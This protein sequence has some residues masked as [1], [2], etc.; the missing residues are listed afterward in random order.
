MPKTANIGETI[1]FACQP[2]NASPKPSVSWFKDGREVS[3]SARVQVLDSGNLR[4]EQVTWADA[5]VYWCVASSSAFQR[6]SEKAPLTVR[7]RPYFVVA[8]ASQFVP[9]NGVLELACRVAGEPQPLIMWKRD[10]PVP[11]I[12]SNRATLLSDGS[13]RIVNVQPED[14]GNYICQASSEGGVVEAVARIDIISSPGFTS[15]PPGYVVTLEGTTIHL[16]CAASGS[17][18]PE[19]RWIRKETS[20]YYVGGITTSSDRI[21]TGET[22]S[23]II[24]SARISD[25]GT[26]ECRASSPVGLTRT[27][28][29][30]HVRPNPSLFPGRVGAVSPPIIRLSS[31]EPPDMIK[32]LCSV[33]EDSGFVKYMSID[34]AD[35]TENSTQSFPFASYDL[36]WYKGDQDLSLNMHPNNRYS[37]EPDGS[38]VIHHL[39]ESDA[40]NY[41]CSVTSLVSKR[42]A[43]WDIRLMFD[44][45]PQHFVPTVYFHLLPAAPFDLQVSAV[46]DSWISLKWH[47]DGSL[48]DRFQVFFL[49]QTPSANYV[50]PSKSVLQMTSASEENRKYQFDYWELAKESTSERRFNLLGLLPD[51][52]YWIEVR[53]FNAFGWS[54]GSIFPRPVYTQVSSFVVFPNA[55]PHSDSPEV[56]NA[57]IDKPGGGR[58]AQDFQ[59]MVSRMH[60]IAFP[61]VSARSL[62]SSEVLVSW[63]TKGS[64]GALK[65][66]DGFLISAKPVFMSR[67]LAAASSNIKANRGVSAQHWIFGGVNSY[68]G[69]L[70]NDRTYCSFSN[71]F[72]LEKIHQD[73]LLG[74]IGHL[75]TSVSSG[76][77]TS[78]RAKPIPD[79]TVLVPRSVSREDPTTGTVIGD[80]H[81]FS[82]YEISVKAFKNDLTYGK[83][84]SRETQAE[85]VMSLDSTPSQAPQLRSANWLSGHMDIKAD[86]RDSQLSIDMAF[87]GA[88]RKFST[89]SHGSLS[90]RS[91]FGGS[92]PISSHGIRLSWAPLDIHVSHGALL[93]YSIHIVANESEFSHSKKVPPDVHMHDVHGL[94]PHVEYTIFLAGIT[95]RG[96]GVRGPGYRMPVLAS[97]VSSPTRLSAAPPF[98][99]WAYGVVCGIVV[100]WITVGLL[101]YL[102]ACRREPRC[103]LHNS[104]AEAKT[105]TSVSA[106]AARTDSIFLISAPPPPST[107]TTN[108]FPPSSASSGTKS[109]QLTD[110]ESSAKAS[111]QA[112]ANLF[113]RRPSFALKNLPSDTR[114]NIELVRLLSQ[115]NSFCDTGGPRINAATTTITAVSS[116]T[117]V[118]L[119]NS[120][121]YSQEEN[122]TKSTSSGSSMTAHGQNT[123]YNGQ[124]V[125]LPPPPNMPF[126]TPMTNKYAEF[127]TADAASSTQVPL[128]VGDPAYSMVSSG[129]SLSGGVSSSFSSPMAHLQSSA[130]GSVFQTPP[131]QKQQQQQPPPSM[132]NAVFLL[133]PNT[134]NPHVVHQFASAYDPSSQWAPAFTPSMTSATDEVPPYASSCLMLPDCARNQ[135]D[136]KPD[137]APS[138]TAPPTTNPVNYLD[139]VS[140]SQSHWS[141]HPTPGITQQRQLQ[142]QL[143]LPPVL[144]VNSQSANTPNVV[145]VSTAIP[146]PP[147]YP[148]PPLPMGG[149]GGVATASAPFTGEQFR[150]LSDDGSLPSSGSALPPPCPSMFRLFS[151]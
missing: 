92:Y 56:S 74:G 114:G 108:P 97:L 62:S 64:S 124:R 89:D 13:L 132:S 138:T 38:L 4:I 44:V 117:P 125:Q 11:V 47:H 115:A 96:E 40:A 14:V 134:Q 7:Q 1:L 72:F 77:E 149:A 19:I 109:S 49:L 150:H 70:L 30:L 17:P 146:P 63:T 33:P 144:V 45:N 112:A 52:G 100:V 29:K 86:T 8:P 27:T 99:S 136:S 127:M 65:L 3:T 116:E 137:F 82:C 102:C 12:P 2:P 148:P 60:G 128:V 71:E 69:A 122:F 24:K 58:L 113:Q 37:V 88:S 147:P 135:T 126:P 41:T 79:R 25:A 20:D 32:L 15:T 48:Q 35:N 107:V 81:P 111:E 9:L 18:S 80:L 28:T 68:V 91:V 121:N 93:G 57:L 151:L 94:N 123:Y 139:T 43:V 54:Q 16:P 22:G 141:A 84:W 46:G 75:P 145:A 61:R 133:P 87:T 85:L 73:A 129:M 142:H 110:C 76:N 42:L 26:Y 5:G 83:I 36:R 21:T 34:S 103:C 67:C 23:L 10:P 118:L 39:M 120:V 59:D 90:N 119:Q 106:T 105:K 104:V 78:N 131:Q 66:V 130:D 6:I 55:F 140:V 143:V 51:S 98:P 53:A 101:V 50:S 95:C 31:R